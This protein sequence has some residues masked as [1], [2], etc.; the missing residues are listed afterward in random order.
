MTVCISGSHRLLAV[1][2]VLLAI[3]ASDA[4]A[5]ESS[6][7]DATQRI[8][9]RSRLAIGA[10]QFVT[11]VAGMTEHD[12]DRAIRDQLEAGNLPAFL[13]RASAVDVDARLGDGERVRL[14]LCVLPDYLSIG[15]DDD[16]LLIPMSLDAALSVGALF[17]FALPT[18]R[19][20]DL[21]YRQASVH[22]APQPLPP[23]DRMRSTA[24]Y[25]EHDAMVRQQREA[26]GA[27]PGELTAGHMKDVVISTRLRSQPGHVAIYGWHRSVDSPIQPLST[28][29]GARYADYSHGVRLVSQRV[30]VNG[31]ARSLFDV[32]ADPRLS[33]LLSDE[34]PLQLAGEWFVRVSPPISGE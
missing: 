11:E 13:R 24:Y 3:A 2:T 29:H 8:P 4:S 12:R 33:R 30:Y 15:S 14:T 26:F 21:I 16:N 9:Q 32:L 22:L 17:G 34:G 6:C 7:A 20:V 18:P 23:G 19:I 27:R 5:A 1:A 31:E 28:V 25:L 10:A